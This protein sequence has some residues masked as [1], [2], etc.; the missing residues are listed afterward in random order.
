[1]PDAA[2]YRSLWLADDSPTQSTC[3]NEVREQNGVYGSTFLPHKFKIGLALP[4][5]NCVDV[6]AQDIGLLMSHR[7]ER[8]D[9]YQVLVGGGMSM[10]PSVP[11]NSPRLAQPLTFVALGRCWM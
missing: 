9:G 2:A 11:R 3:S 7:E 10:I 8:V 6:Y 4:E 1:M 5:D